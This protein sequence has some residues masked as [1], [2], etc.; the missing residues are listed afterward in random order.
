MTE[1]TKK[2]VLLATDTATE[3]NID[4]NG[5]ALLTENI[6]EAKNSDLSLVMN[7]SE[8]R[9]D[10]RDLALNLNNGHRAVVALIDKYLPQFQKFGQV[11]FKKAVGD[12]AQGG[13]N[14]ER[15]ALLN[16]D[17]SYFLLSLS[18]NTERVVD[19]KVRLVKAFREARRA[20]DIRQTEYLP[21]YHAL[22]AA[23]HEVAK[24]SANEHHIHSNFNRL[25]NKAVGI[26]A[27]QRA[28]SAAPTQSLLS[29]VQTIVIKAIRSATGHRDAY[30]RAK[31][32]LQAFTGTLALAT[33]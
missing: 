28:C 8:A 9:V 33:V 6:S 22:H 25:I 24:D 16:E 20:T 4:S 7:K 29:V 15:Y 18:R 30:A 11:L 26:A 3:H 17:Q 12:R 14:A 23:I 27:G 1:H 31:L 10:S 5:A 19:L 13:G 2:A 32:A 21:E